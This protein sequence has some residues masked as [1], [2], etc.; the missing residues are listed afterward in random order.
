MMTKTLPLNG[1]AVGFLCVLSGCNGITNV[2]YQNT[3][4][5]GSH[6]NHA[7]AFHAT[8]GLDPSDAYITMPNTYGRV[9]SVGEK[10]YKNGIQQ[11]IV[12]FAAPEVTGENYIEV[13]LVG[14]STLYELGQKLKLPG[15]EIHTLN[16]VSKREFGGRP[17][18]AP[19]ISAINHY[20]VY[21][22]SY[23]R[24]GANMG[25]ILGWQ[26]LSS[27]TPVMEA[28]GILKK[29]GRKRQKT[30][31]ADL[32]YRI[33]FCKQGLTL[34]DGHNLMKTLEISAS[35]E[36]LR[37]RKASRWYAGSSGLS[38]SQTYDLPS[39]GH[40]HAEPAIRLEPVVQREPVVSPIIDPEPAIVRAKK[41][42]RKT[43]RSAS[44]AK[45]EQVPLP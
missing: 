36:T 33:R 2:S 35:P 14:R 32:S 42:I 8:N 22:L 44:T 43:S 34:A 28:E 15:K 41:V 13:N 24:M 5:I 6:L 11:R 45:F 3:S 39:A 18:S 26:K 9:L 17:I 23:T 4:S 20:G 30:G 21:G 10:L 7:Q 37:E 12:F 38:H 1:L 31:K 40:L 27:H 29:I 19:D 25:C 16:A